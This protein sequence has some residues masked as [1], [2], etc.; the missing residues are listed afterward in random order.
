MELGL[1]FFGR[2]QMSG[3]GEE[4]RFFLSSICLSRIFFSFYTSGMRV[5]VGRE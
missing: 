2:E 3:V 1:L 4:T 5:C